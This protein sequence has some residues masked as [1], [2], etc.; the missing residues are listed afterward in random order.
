M[1]VKNIT[2]PLVQNG[3]EEG[4]LVTTADDVTFRFDEIVVAVPLGCLKRSKP[5]FSPPLPAELVRSIGHVGYGRL[6]KV[7]VFFA[8][9]FWQ[10]KGCTGSKPFEFRFLTP[11]YALEQNPERWSMEC[12]CL[13]A[14]P[15]PCDSATLIFYLHGPVGEHVTSLVRGC[16]QGSAEQYQRLDGFF[17]PYYTRLPNYEPGGCRP[18]GFCST[19]WQHDGLAGNGSYTT[20]Q[21]SD[22][23]KDGLVEL[24]KDLAILR[25]GCPERKLWFAGEHTATIKALGTTTGAWWSGEEVAERMGHVYGLG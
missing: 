15:M 24:D 18:I 25:Q 11:T 7:Y 13:S 1:T 10:A 12:L 3:D 9:A 22:P 8:T 19:D 16:E 2:T 14:L 20:F 6:E 5:T 4:V 17:S 23:E 21:V